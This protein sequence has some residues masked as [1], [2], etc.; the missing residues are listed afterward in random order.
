MK[1]VTVKEVAEKINL[2]RTY[3]SKIFHRLEGITI[4]NYLTGIRM[5][6]AK[7]LLLESTYNIQEISITVGIPDSY[8]FSRVFKK[9][10]GFT[11]TQYRRDRLI[12]FN[13]SPYVDVGTFDE[14]H[15]SEDNKLIP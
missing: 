9:Y 3:L 8:Y 6:S 2:D 7:R 1:P 14:L 11:P 10:S 12:E 15:Y 4:H 13:S 5:E